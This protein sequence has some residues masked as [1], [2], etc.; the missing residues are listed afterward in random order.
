MSDAGKRLLAAAREMRETVRQDMDSVEIPEDIKAAA[1]S[2]VDR[3]YNEGLV[4]A[5]ERAIL[6]ERERCAKI[7]HGVWLSAG[8]GDFGGGMADA[9]QSIEDQI[10]NGA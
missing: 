2:V 6:A 10:R 7:A 1:R 8:G 4:D 9:A 3:G 5:V